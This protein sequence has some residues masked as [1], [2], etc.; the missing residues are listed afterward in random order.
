[1]A[2]QFAAAWDG[3]EAELRA[4]WPERVDERGFPDAFLEDWI[5][6]GARATPCAFAAAEAARRVVGLAHVG[7]LETL[8]DDAKAA[9]SRGVI[10]AVER[11]LLE[12]FESAEAVA[13]MAVRGDGVTRASCARRWPGRGD[14]VEI[15][16]QTRLPAEEVVLRLETPEEVV[17]AIRRLAVRGAPAIGICGAFGVV[18]AAR[19][20]PAGGGR[21]GDP[22]RAAD[23]GQP[24]AGRSTA[25]CAAG[26]SARRRGGRG[27]SRSSRRTSRRAG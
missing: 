4:L 3:F 15:I 13:A 12:R 2:A 25:C 20:R 17:D 21:R 27:A 26:P 23:R 14:A 8:E 16:D 19:R 24:R 7:D 6:A 9:A 10:A 11:L 1:M 22:R 18:L 5:D